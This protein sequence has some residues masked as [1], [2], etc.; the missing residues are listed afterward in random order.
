MTE[1][2][3]FSEHLQELKR[4]LLVFGIIFAVIS[5]L[6]FTL[7]TS[8]IGF[9]AKEFSLI[10]LEPLDVFNSTMLIAMGLT[11]LLSFPIAIFLVIDYL[12]PAF[13]SIKPIVKISIISI[14]L[15][16]FGF[17]FGAIV[18]S[19]I[20]A[21]LAKQFSS[22]LGITTL[23]G[24]LAFVKFVILNGMIFAFLFQL[25]LL[26]LIGLKTNFLDEKKLTKNS[27]LAVPVIFLV[28]GWLTPP[29]PFSLFL[30]AVPLTIMFYASI[31]ISIKLKNWG[32]I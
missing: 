15:F 31:F 14:T 24:S 28:S 13:T 32:V 5:V 23:W 2:I 10:S 6:N 17:A 30:M 16:Y 25:P 9:L 20:L 29:D 1:L 12:K 3:T 7:A 11:L 8:I 19:G 18:F 26:I 21:M 4:K 22:D 27:W